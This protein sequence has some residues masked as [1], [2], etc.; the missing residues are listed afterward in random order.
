MDLLKA[1]IAKKRKL[2]QA[3]FL[4][5]SE[6][7]FF[8]REELIKKNEDEYWRKQ[9][10]KEEKKRK[11]INGG[12][13][14]S[15]QSSSGDDGNKDAKS[16]EEET[17]L[18]LKK[19]ISNQSGS[20]SMNDKA[21]IEERILSRKEV[22]KRLR[23]RNQPILLFGEVEIDAFRRLRKLEIVEP[24][25]SDKGLR[26]DFQ[27]SSIVFFNGFLILEIL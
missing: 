22:I 3:D 13:D 21:N 27:V 26:N 14:G 18:K 24:D 15:Y 23:E 11:S 2:L 12:I 25:A 9:A 6:K 20:N 19:F 1:E 17:K 10:E 16:S 7:K 4:V 8:K 5:N